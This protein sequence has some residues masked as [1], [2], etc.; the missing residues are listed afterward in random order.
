M[1]LLIG[2][3]CGAL[4]WVV[5]SFIHVLFFNGSGILHELFHPGAHEIWMRLV[6]V[7]VTGIFG[8]SMDVLIYRH[9]LSEEKVAHLNQV[10]R[11]IRGVDRLIYREKDRSVFIQKACRDLIEYRG[12]NS[13]WIALLDEAQKPVEWAQAH[14]NENAPQHIEELLH[15]ELPNCALK[16]LNDPEGG[17]IENPSGD[18]RECP[19]TH[20]YQDWT[21]F[22]ARLAYRG[23]TYGV[24]TASVPRRYARDPEEQNL[25]REVAQDIAF[26]LYNIQRNEEHRKF[27]R[28]LSIKDH[29]IAS[30]IEAIAIAGL[31]RRLSYVNQSFLRLWGYDQIDDALGRSIVHFWQDPHEASG[32]VEAMETKGSWT[33]E[34]E[35]RKQDGTSFVVRLSA[36]M[37]KDDSGTPVCMMASITDVTEMKKAEQSLRES[38]QIINRSP[39]VT[40]LW[41]NEPG[42]PVEFVSDNVANIFG[43]TRDEFISGGRDYAEAVHPDDLKRVIGEVSY[44]CSQPEIERF[45]HM[46]YRIV[47]RNGKIRWVEDRTYIRRDSEGR[48]THFQGIVLDI[49]DRKET[50]QALKH[51][52]EQLRHAQRME[53][54]GRLAGGIAHDFNNLLTTII[55]YTDLLQLKNLNTTEGKAAVQEIRSAVERAAA[56]TQAL[57]AFSRKQELNPQR[58]DLNKLIQSMEKMLRRIIGE[59]IRLITRLEPDLDSVYADR[60]QL[61]QVIINL[62]INA[63]DAMKG[64]GKLVLETTNTELTEE[65]RKKNREIEPGSYVRINVEDT[66]SGIESGV[67]EKIFEPYFTTKSTGKGTGLGLSTVY[68]IVKQSGGFIDVLSEPGQGTTFR[69]F[70][71]TCSHGELD[72]KTRAVAET[73]RG[74]KETILL[75]EDE[76]S[77]R[78]MAALIL[79]KYGYQVIDVGLAPEAIE[80]IKD[81]GH[82]KIDLLI[83]DVVMPEM[84]GPELSRELHKKQPKLKTLFISGYT[85]SEINS[86]HIIEDGAIL[87]HKPFTITKLAQK[88]REILDGS[89]D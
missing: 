64:G 23:Y 18:C 43:Y 41:R 72:E 20:I 32:V 25:F 42:W 2:I 14:I 63:R 49:S 89:N 56:L 67:Q 54:I 57:L 26:S 6:V 76:D 46:P 59:D 53:A 24:M 65:T 79:R 47:T 4:F 74:G 45:I 58:L 80:M 5:E 83:S 52:E 84:N 87:L 38:Y 12:F 85:G 29:A 88:V 27:E 1:M 60:G 71:P 40:F 70:L 21:A 61:E 33:G 37:A 13:A 11:S 77:V 36:S 10:L 22:S 51:S 15:F 8:A 75:V 82:L 69:I 31:D 28:E 62:A 50:E 17:I 66:G 3:G 19:L 44:F 55:G 35:A 9:G 48:A 30:S 78:Q 7:V 34:M 39:A 86:R 68:G 73:I 16:V 81:A